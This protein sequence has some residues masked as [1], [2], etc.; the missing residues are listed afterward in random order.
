MKTRKQWIAMLLMLVMLFTALPIAAFAEDE[1]EATV[2]EEESTPQEPE[3]QPE[4]TEEEQL[5]VEKQPVMEPVQMGAPGPEGVAID[6]TNFPDPVF[7]DYVSKNIDRDKNGSL[8][9][10]ELD[11]VKE[12]SYDFAFMPDGKNVRTPDNEIVPD[13]ADL[14]KLK[15][16]K[17]IEHFKNLE[18]LHVVNNEITDLDVSQ[19]AK[20]W[21]LDCK[22]NKLTR[23]DVSQNKA[24]KGFYCNNNELESL[25]IGKLP[26]LKGFWCHENKNL[27]S[28][29]VTQVPNLQHLYCNSTG[30]TALDLSKNP[31]LETIDC[32]TT[33]ITELDVSKNTKLEWLLCGNNQLTELDLSKNTELYR[34]FCYTNQLTQLDLSNNPKLQVLIFANNHITN[35]DLSKNAK[36]LKTFFWGV[37][38]QA[39]AGENQNYTI[40]VDKNKRTFDLSKLPGKFD[41]TKASD[42]VGGSVNGTTLTI[43]TPDPND[44][45]KPEKVTYIYTPATP[46]GV[47]TDEIKKFDVTLNIEWYAEYTV[48]FDAGE[49]GTGTMADQIA[50]EGPFT[51]PQSKF[52]APEGQVFKG[53]QVI[54]AQGKVL[55]NGLKAGEKIELTGNI[56]LKALWKTPSSPSNATYETIVVEANEGVWNDGTTKAKEYTVKAGDEITLPEAPTREGYKFIGWG[57]GYK[58]GDK[59]V[60]PAGGHTFVA[61]WEK[62]EKKPEEKPS[63]DSKIKTPR[64]SALTPEEIA[65]ILAG[66]KTVVPAIPRAGV[67][68]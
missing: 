17:G 41:G 19:N 38:R 33:K 45:T 40:R 54:D 16:L 50:P 18:Q 10:S 60:V 34:L 2:V 24:L 9:Q 46:D 66:S 6:E 67:G 29:D 27:T 1:P 55:K 8:D 14:P 25:T 37:Q 47:L 11:G 53:W 15:N 68:R 21:L 52:T 20:L 62:D 13:S 61:Q 56:T 28:L 57:D 64:G 35:M 26:L 43:A 30:I 49:G 58:P 12:I 65:K 51:L 23:L 22:F 36:L 7:R 59:Y 31:L 3:A 4:E 32:N 39:Y 48:K 63:V 42:W 44:L 5:E